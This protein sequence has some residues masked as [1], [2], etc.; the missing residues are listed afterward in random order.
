MSAD[1]RIEPLGK[2]N[3]DSWSIQIEA[4]LIKSDDWNYV[5]GETT[6]PE[7]SSGTAYQDELAKFKELAKWELG[8]RKARS[9]LILSISTSELRQIKDCKTS[10]EV[11]RILNRP[12][13]QWVQRENLPFQ[14]N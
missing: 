7:S 14:N 1:R 2:N 4:L 3:Y 6:K 13:S 8:D 9:Y 12:T 5:F 11:C 10:R